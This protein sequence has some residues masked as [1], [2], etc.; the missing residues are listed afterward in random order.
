MSDWELKIEIPN[1]PCGKARARATKGHHYTP[2]DTRAAQRTIGNVARREMRMKGLQMFAAHVP[3]RIIVN[4]HFKGD[5][6]SISYTTRKPDLDNIAKLVCDALNGVAFVDDKQVS[7]IRIEKFS[8][9][10]DGLFIIVKQAMIEEP[11]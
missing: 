3:V 6:F 10:L 8:S 5:D 7:S 4:A 11:C 9:N 1:T 2:L